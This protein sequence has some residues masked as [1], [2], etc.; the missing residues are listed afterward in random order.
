MKNT[1]YKP[2]LSNNQGHIGS[3][4]VIHSHVWIGDKVLIGD[5]VKIQAFA[6]IPNGVVIQDN[7]F[8]GPGVVF[9][10]DK[11]PPSDVLTPTLVKRGAVIGANATIVCGVTIGECAMIAAGAVVTKDVPP[12]TL[13]KGNPAK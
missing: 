3:D 2:E 12:G 11:L 6:F 4:C 7:V 13:V 1:V 5:R 8:I 9:T 10:N